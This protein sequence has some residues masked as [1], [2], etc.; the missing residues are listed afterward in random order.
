MEWVVG[1]WEFEV[2][3]LSSS[4]RKGLEDLKGLSE[5]VTFLGLQ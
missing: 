5:Y 4:R 1:T 3:K 2:A